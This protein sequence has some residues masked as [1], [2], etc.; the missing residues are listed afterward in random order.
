ML[1]LNFYTYGELEAF[2]VMT[3]DLLRN[4][5]LCSATLTE[6]HL[7]GLHLEPCF[8]QLEDHRGATGWDL[9]VMAHLRHVPTCLV[10]GAILTLVVLLARRTPYASASNSAPCA[11]PSRLLD[12]AASRRMEA[13]LW[14]NS[15]LRCPSWP[16]CCG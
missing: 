5:Q 16:R 12:V 7:D 13:K 8:D 4:I 11:S 3:G 2:M 14:R 10:H 9:K 1:H 6:L 15:P